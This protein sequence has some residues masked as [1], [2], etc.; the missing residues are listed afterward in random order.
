M[1]M[2]TLPYIMLLLILLTLAIM[3]SNASAHFIG[4]GIVP[5]QP[6]PD[7]EEA[8]IRPAV[9][10]S[11]AIVKSSLKTNLGGITHK[12]LGKFPIASNNC[13]VPVPDPEWEYIIHKAAMRH[14]SWGDVEAAECKMRA[15]IRAESNWRIDVCSHVGACG[16][17]QLMPK[18][19]EHLG[20][21]DVFDPEQ[22]L[23]AAVQYLAWNTRQFSHAHDRTFDQQAQNGEA[24]YNCGLG[25]VLHWQREYGCNNWPCFVQYANEETSHYVFRIEN[26]S[27][28]GIWISHPPQQYLRG[29][30]DDINTVIAR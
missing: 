18:T 5:S 20:V 22:N 11:H 10:Q 3:V 28:T 2:K 29:D 1:N 30:W 25:C 23:K 16:L 12:S 14:F 17:G 21:T 13:P 8:H 4:N 9:I 15:L 27:K 6:P 24:S 26:Y 19:A 7:L